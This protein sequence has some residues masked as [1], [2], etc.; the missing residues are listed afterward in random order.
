MP[1]FMSC[2][3][4]LATP[5]EQR[6]LGTGR[7]EEARWGPRLPGP[8]VQQVP[9]PQNMSEKEIRKP[10]RG[11]T[12]RSR[13]VWQGG[14]PPPLCLGPPCL[15]PCLGIFVLRSQFAEASIPDNCIH[16]HGD[17]P[18]PDTYDCTHR[19]LDLQRSCPQCSCVAH[20]LWG[21]QLWASDFLSHLLTDFLGSFHIESLAFIL[22]QPDLGK[23]R[24]TKPSFS[25][26]HACSRHHESIPL[27]LLLG[28]GYRICQEQCSGKPC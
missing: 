22:A 5:G 27:L 11:Q 17:T 24:L 18:T 21:C 8:R 20:A 16:M 10:H 15:I 2:P 14:R 7:A 3:R 19:L 13:R 1:P 26:T 23:G 12:L 6:C 4:C 28:L 9:G 25:P